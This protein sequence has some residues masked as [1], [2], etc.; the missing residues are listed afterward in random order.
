MWWDMLI[1]LALGR[2]RKEA[3]DLEAIL[4]YLDRICFQTNRKADQ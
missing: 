1:I 3:Y 4:G 2:V